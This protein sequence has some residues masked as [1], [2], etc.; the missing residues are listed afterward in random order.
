MSILELIVALVIIGLL[1]WGVRT[2]ASAFSIPQPIVAVITV[3]LVIV[4]VLWMLQSLGLVG[5]PVLRLQ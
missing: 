1:F 5:G 3:I 4:V 2:I